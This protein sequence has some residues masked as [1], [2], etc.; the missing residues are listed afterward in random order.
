MMSGGGGADDLVD[1]D[2]GNDNDVCFGDGDCGT[3]D[4]DVDDDD[5]DDDDGGPLIFLVPWVIIR[6]TLEDDLCWNTHP[7]KEIFWL[8]KAPQIAIVVVNFFFFVKI[9]R[10]LFTKLG[11][12]APP[13]ARKYRYRRLGKSTLVLIPI[14]GVHYMLTILVPENLDRIVETV[15]LYF[16]MVFNSFQGVLI[17]CLFCFMNGEVRKTVRSEI[18]KRYIRHKLRVNSRQFQNKFA[19]TA[20]SNMRA[21]TRPSSSPRMESRELHS[22]SGSDNPSGAVE[23]QKLRIYCQP[24]RY[25]RAQIPNGV[26]DT[27]PFFYSGEKRNSYV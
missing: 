26:P 17:A 8:L 2:Y 15:K 20:C 19:S 9:V 16:E 22:S 12:T 24:L 27:K 3:D 21:R 10:V 25:Y 13:R 6:A 14:F 1:D 4:V 7:T 18:R 11:R 23:R 5:D